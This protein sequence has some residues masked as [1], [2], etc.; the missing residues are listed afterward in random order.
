MGGIVGFVDCNGEDKDQRPEIDIVNCYN[1]GTVVG[2]KKNTGGIVG[3]AI[4][5]KTK[6]GDYWGAYYPGGREE[7]VYG[8]PKKHS[9][10]I[11]IRNCYSTGTVDGGTKDAAGIVAHIKGAVTVQ[12]CYSAGSVTADDNK[13]AH[14]IVHWSESDYE[15]TWFDK[16]MVYGEPISRC[17]SV[18]VDGHGWQDDMLTDERHNGSVAKPEWLS[19]ADGYL[20]NLQVCDF[21]QN[22]QD[23]Q[24]RSSLFKESPSADINGGFYILGRGRRRPGGVNRNL[25]PER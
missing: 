8:I 7:Y 6:K 18:D 16:S 24:E 9:D 3:E 10:I 5:H 14:G 20:E 2:T 17:Y 13:T 19:S 25:S 4:A 23:H 1:A 21:Y 22:A 12:G 11:I 15:T